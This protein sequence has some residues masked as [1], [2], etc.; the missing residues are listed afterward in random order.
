MILEEKRLITLSNGGRY[1]LVNDLGEIE[2]EEGKK[3]FF[4]IGVTPDYDLDINDIIFLATFQEDGET[5]VTRVDEGTKLYNT[6]SYLEVVSTAMENIPG[7]KEQLMEE[8]DK[9]N[10]ESSE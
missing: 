1:L 9:L 6:L 8:I 10:N 7:Y 5:V 2:G 3:F 4:A